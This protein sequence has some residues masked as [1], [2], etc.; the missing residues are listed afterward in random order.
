MAPISQIGNFAERQHLN[1][2]MLKIQNHRRCR[3]RKP[4]ILN[5]HI[6]NRDQNRSQQKFSKNN[7]KIADCK[8]ELRSKAN[9]NVCLCPK[10]KTVLSYLKLKGS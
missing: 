4:F 3:Q 5:S 10:S 8:S 1:N 7:L 6:T 9:N 2:E